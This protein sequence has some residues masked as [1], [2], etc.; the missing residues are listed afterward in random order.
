M[1]KKSRLE[2]IYQKIFFCFQ[3][4]QRSSNDKC[5]LY[6]LSASG[7]TKSHENLVSYWNVAKACRIWVINPCAL[8]MR[9]LIRSSKSDDKAIGTRALK[10][11]IS[12]NT[13]IHK[14]KGQQI[15]AMSNRQVQSLNDSQF[16]YSRVL[17]RHQNKWDFTCELNS[18]KL[19]PISLGAREKYS[20]IN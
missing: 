5:N 6:T 19:R 12:V 18:D 9:F 20:H 13:E 14:P 15:S 17:L 4:G 10:N 1:C 8:L 3:R 16:I 7:V 11:S 2:I